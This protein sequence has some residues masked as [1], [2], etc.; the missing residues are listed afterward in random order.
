MNNIGGFKCIELLYC[1]EVQTFGIVK[2]QVYLVKKENKKRILPV[3]LKGATTETNPSYS[4]GGRSHSHR[5]DIPLLNTI[6]VALLDELAYVDD[7]GFLLIVENHNG[8]KK[9]YGTLDA[10]LFGTIIDI[11]GSTPADLSYKALSIPGNTI[12]KALS[13]FT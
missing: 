7:E 13:L 10:P 4:N 9:V 3:L 1:S 8:Q 2:N 6:K 5:V 11:D 12:H